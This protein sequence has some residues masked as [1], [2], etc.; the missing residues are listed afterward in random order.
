M[1]PMTPMSERALEMGCFCSTTLMAQTTA[2]NPKRKKN[3]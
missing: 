3:K 2:M 1:D